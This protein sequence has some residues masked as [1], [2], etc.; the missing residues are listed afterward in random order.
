[1]QITDKSSTEM[2]EAKGS[3]TDGETVTLLLFRAGGDTPKAVPLAIPSAS[4]TKIS[5]RPNS[6]GFSANAPIAAVPTIAT[7]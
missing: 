1:M 3:R 6:S 2:L 4:P 7:A 5:N